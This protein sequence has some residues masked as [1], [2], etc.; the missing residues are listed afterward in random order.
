MQADICVK[1][2]ERCFISPNPEKDFPFAFSFTVTYG[3]IPNADRICPVLRE[4]QDRAV[5]YPQI[6][7][8]GFDKLLSESQKIETFINNLKKS[9]DSD[10]IIKKASAGS[11]IIIRYTGLELSS[12]FYFYA[13][14]ES[15]ISD[16][17]ENE[18]VTL[19]VTVENFDN[20]EDNQYIIS[21]KVDYVP[22]AK[23]VTFSQSPV[24]LGAQV[25][26]GYEYLGDKTDKKLMQNGIK[27]DTAR[28]PY[29]ATIGR[30]ALFTLMAFN[31]CGMI[32]TKDEFL[33]VLPPEIL[34]F[35][36]DRHYFS[37]GEAV[38][39]QWSLSS[40]SNFAI[41]N[42]DKEKDKVE[43][44]YA[45]VY[46]A[47]SGSGQ[48]AVYTLRANGYK[49]GVP[50]SVSKN[51]TLTRTLWKKAGIQTGYF[52]GDVY[53]D[54][55]YN[56]R[57]FREG[58]YYYCYAHPWLYRSGD[59][60]KWEKYSANDKA[61][62]QFVCIAAD[63]YDHVFYAMG[64]NGADGNRLYISKYD[65][66]VSGWEHTSAYQSCCSDIGGF[67]FSRTVKAYAQVLK[68]GIMIARC[69]ADGKWCHGG[70]SISA[71][72]NK[73]VIGGDYCFYKNAFYAVMLC[74][75]S[76]VYVY[77]CEESM[78]D[79]LFKKEVDKND[80]F[81]SLIPTI[82]RLYLVTA[83]SLTDVKTGRIADDFSP[84]G[85]EQ[86]KRMWIGSSGDG[87]LMGIYPDRNLWTLA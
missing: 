23:S 55:K 69:G 46:P 37:E 36:A 34:S 67:A 64:K 40:V 52:A 80:R 13:S 66:A 74:S 3:Y 68:N 56:C 73:D 57:I 4:P 49:E 85:G 2:P 10:W 78:E 31:D 86:N 79:I 30:P 65:F 12:D 21:T 7:I 83:G 71:P 17:K 14:T 33:D 75:D 11:D 54:L 53:G 1:I 72:E 84:M 47:A 76:Y 60:L 61:D 87:N 20:L 70:S 18:I 28:S 32:D 25:E 48:K 39:L 26:V 35:T 41:D 82:N 38:T 59:G 44:T 27:V 62:G 51:L 58:E 15:F 16:T 8:S 63:C 81:V 22:W 5:K 9:G 45:V 29:T 6:T 19:T 42:I 43:K 24:A 50:A 77:N